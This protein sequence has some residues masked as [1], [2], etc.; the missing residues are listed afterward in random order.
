MLVYHVIPQISRKDSTTAL[1]SPCW[2]VLFMRQILRLCDELTLFVTSELLVDLF[3]DQNASLDSAVCAILHVLFSCQSPF[4]SRYSVELI[5]FSPLVM[6]MI[7]IALQV[8]RFLCRVSLFMVCAQ[9]GKGLPTPG[10]P[11][12]VC[13]FCSSKVDI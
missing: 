10:V 5:F 4:G 7:C 6:S 12:Y 11:L 1:H 2:E 8:I 9:V 13:L 3:I